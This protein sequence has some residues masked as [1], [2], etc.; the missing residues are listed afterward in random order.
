MT[1]IGGAGR[2]FFVFVG[3]ADGNFVADLTKGLVTATSGGYSFSV[4]LVSV[5]GVA[6]TTGNDRFIGDATDNIFSIESGADTVSGGGGFDVVAQSLD[7]SNFYARPGV[8]AD[9][10][11]GTLSFYYATSTLTSIEGVLGDT[12]DD[13][14][15]GDGLA[16]RFWPGLGEDQILGRLGLDTVSYDT[17]YSYSF[18]D[19][20]QLVRD[21]VGGVS[22]N[23]TL[24]RATKPDGSVDVLV[25][26]ERVLGSL[27]QDTLRGSAAADT[28]MGGGGA[29]RLYGGG[30]NDQL[31]GFHDNVLIFGV[32]NSDGADTIDGGAGL[33]SLVG[34]LGDDSLIGG[35]GADLLQGGDGDDELHGFLGNSGEDASLLD[36]AD[37]LDGGAGR[38]VLRG[39]RGNDSL[40]GGDGDDNMRGDAGSDTIDGG[41]GYDRAVY[42]FDELTLSSGVSFSGARIG[43]SI[44][45]LFG[46]GRGGQD[47]L[48]GIEACNI[49]GTG[50]ADTLTGSPGDDFLRGEGGDDI[51]RGG[52]GFDIVVFDSAPGAVQGD[53][54]LL[55]VL[56]AEGADTLAGV[57]GLSGGDFGDTFKGNIGANLLEGMAGNDTLSGLGGDDT[58]YGGSGADVIDGS[59]GNDLLLGEAGRDRLLGSSGN[60]TLAGLAGADTLTGGAGR[61]AFYFYEGPEGGGVF[62]TIKDFTVGVDKI[63][64]Y[65]PAF[66]ALDLDGPLSASALTVGNSATTADHRL[67]FDDQTG[68]LYY[69]ADGAGGL[70]Q[71]VLA[72]ITLSAG[73]LSAGDFVIFS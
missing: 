42:R 16:N 41:A 67:I 30:G 35:A 10:S 62:D 4:S 51:I 5:E 43:S 31:L 7:S 46:D 27:G 38:D 19:Q 12:F 17:M 29:D 32:H 47:L 69:D 33:D 45:V 15:L 24:G 52:S 39:N 2:D 58:I 40:S 56:G 54:S 13:K 44:E 3:D 20:G 50:F 37:T 72:T 66:T 23:L 36:G 18:D 53:L 14:L 11:L 60:D 64:L 1:V 22:V 25:G 65:S 70:A 59:L 26:I 71:E 63:W 49:T 48:R 68:R 28:L 61:D 73:A 34:G 9:L 8:V 6:G 57:E 21:A 55:R